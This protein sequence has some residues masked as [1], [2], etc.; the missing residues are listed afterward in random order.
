MEN[1]E[2][3]PLDYRLPAIITFTSAICAL[4]FFGP[5]GAGWACAAIAALVAMPTKGRII[6]AP[7]I[8]PI[9]LVTLAM[10]YLH[11]GEEWLT[12]FAFHFPQ[13]MGFDPWSDPAYM[14]MTGANLAIVTLG[15]FPLLAGSRTGTYAACFLSLLA[16][17]N[18]LAH[19]I[20]AIVFAENWYFSGLVTAVP[21]LLLGMKMWI[22]I[23]SRAQ[24]P[25]SASTITPMRSRQPKR[26][27]FATL[28]KQRLE[29]ASK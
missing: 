21:H 7:K 10:Q 11:I 25:A 8:L 16:I 22:D 29:Q 3:N 15:I 13:E 27:G 18:G 6:Y 19:P 26:D 4:L 9:Y 28:R 24:A 17:I 23:G 1:N 12:G 20:L 2:I 5:P 14:M